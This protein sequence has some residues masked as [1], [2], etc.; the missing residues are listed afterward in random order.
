M[1][2]LKKYFLVYLTLATLCSYTNASL[3]IE[4]IKLAATGLFTQGSKKIKYSDCE[5]FSKEK[6]DEGTVWIKNPDGIE[7]NFFIALE[8]MICLAS[9]GALVAL[10]D[11]CDSLAGKKVC[12][13]VTVKHSEKKIKKGNTRAALIFEPEEGTNET[14]ESLVQ[15]FKTAE[16]KVAVESVKLMLS[17][18]MLAQEKLQEIQPNKIFNAELSFLD[19]KNILTLCFMA[20]KPKPS[21]RR[22]DRYKLIVQLED[23]IYKNFSTMLIWPT[24]PPILSDKQ[25]QMT[26]LEYL[27]SALQSKDPTLSK[28]KIKAEESVELEKSPKSSS[29]TTLGAPLP[30]APFPTEPQ[31]AEPATI[32]PETCCSTSSTSSTPPQK[33]Y[34][35]LNLSKISFMSQAIA[36]LS[37]GG[38]SASEIMRLGIHDLGFEKETVAG[39]KFDWIEPVRNYVKQDRISPRNGYLLFTDETGLPLDK[40]QIENII[41]LYDLEKTPFI[42]RAIFKLYYDTELEPE[43]IAALNLEDVDFETQKVKIKFKGKPMLLNLSGPADDDPNF[44]PCSESESDPEYYDSIWPESVKETLEGYVAKRIPLVDRKALFTS[45]EGKRISANFVK[46]VIKRCEFRM[47]LMD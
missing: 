47:E 33:T 5:I 39:I 16:Q 17:N 30:A 25:A 11:Q 9:S 34:P 12:S 14:H 6:N 45:P 7:L 22:P 29:S 18:L 35:M 19:S 1:I 15:L 24:P 41:E 23:S 32:A 8:Q 21:G 38:Y 4:L 37:M 28:L 46:R 2:A 36:K 10:S 44:D 31:K 13:S 43:E 26:I 20:G 42:E 3:K 40:K 27:Q